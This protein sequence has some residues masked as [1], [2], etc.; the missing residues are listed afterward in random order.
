MSWVRVVVQLDSWIPTY[1]P[2]WLSMSK[3]AVCKGACRAFTL[4]SSYMD[5]IEC[6]QV[7][8]LSTQAQYAR[9]RLV[10]RVRTR[11]PIPPKYSSISG[12][13]NALERPPEARRASKTA[14]LDCRELRC[15]TASLYDRVAM[16][17]EL[18]EKRRYFTDSERKKDGVNRLVR[19]RRKEEGI[20]HVGYGTIEVSR[21]RA[22]RTP[23]N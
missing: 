15:S 6:I 8:R 1:L 4:R 19:M 2:I 12:I 17:Q 11:Y 14:E 21:S 13:A 16:V 18:E 20:G 3:D 22:P 23:L 7:L 10:T 5:Y 9:R